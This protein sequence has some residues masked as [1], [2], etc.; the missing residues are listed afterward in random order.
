MSNSIEFD[1]S[2]WGRFALNRDAFDLQIRR[3][4]SQSGTAAARADAQGFEVSS[5]IDLQYQL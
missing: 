4:R 5:Q 2:V 1:A 3:E